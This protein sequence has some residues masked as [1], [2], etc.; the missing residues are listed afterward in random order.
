MD[1]AFYRL[2]GASKSQ[3]VVFVR[4]FSYADIILMMLICPFQLRI[5]CGSVTSAGEATQRNTKSP[6]GS[7]KNH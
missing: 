6:G 5:F 2:E 3:A 4:D 7:W 1:E